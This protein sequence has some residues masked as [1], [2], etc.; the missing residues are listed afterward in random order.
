MINMTATK[1]QK[2]DILLLSTFKTKII[3]FQYVSLF[4]L[5]SYFMFCFFFRS[6]FIFSFL[7]LFSLS[8]LS[9]FHF[10]FVV[11]MNF[12]TQTVGLQAA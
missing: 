11:I 5:F 10:I 6:F 3:Y 2:K 12:L 8:F 7:L 4:C 9:C 1:T